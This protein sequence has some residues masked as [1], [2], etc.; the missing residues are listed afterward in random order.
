MSLAVVGDWDADGVV[1]AAQ[2]FYSQSVLGV[3]PL[4]NKRNVLLIPASVRSVVN[5]V[6]EIVESDIG[7]VVFLDIAY[8]NYMDKALSILYS[9]GIKV[10]YVDHHISTE[11]HVNIIKPKVEDMIIGRTSTAMLVYNKLK[12]LGIEVSERLKAFIE[13]VTIIERGGGYGIGKAPSKLIDIVASL[14][15]ALVKSRDRDLWIKIVKWLTEPL[16]TLSLPF[17][18][19]VLHFAKPS[20][21]HLKELKVIASEIALSSIRIFNVRLVDIRGKRYPYKSTAIASALHR[22]LRSPIAVVT[23]NK[24]GQDILIL[25]SSGTLAYNIALH[26]YRKGL[27]RDLMGHQTLVIA[28][29]KPGIELG[30]IIEGIREALVSGPAGI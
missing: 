10:L 25:K 26:L 5:V 20:P 2:I 14:S 3:Y 8:S 22:L 11:I 15:R 18:L 19:N 23:K 1:S 27:V 7:Y 29:L 4:R 17:A 24:H 6:K 28:L 9:K 30:K 13:A 21:E 16:P 12:S